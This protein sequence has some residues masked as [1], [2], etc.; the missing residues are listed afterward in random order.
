ADAIW[1]Y[2]VQSRDARAL[3]FLADLAQYVADYGLYQG[4]EGIDKVMPW[5]L[6][7]SQKTF[8]DAGPWGD[9]EHTCDVAGL[10]ARG[11]WARRELGGDPAPLVATAESLLDGCAW[12][13]DMW[14]RPGSE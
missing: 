4:G 7:S 1:E 11:A 13:L 14:Y 3:T 12:N 2:Y 10:V 8:S 6:S 5:Y 9:I